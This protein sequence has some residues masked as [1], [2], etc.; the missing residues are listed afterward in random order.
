[1]FHNLKMKIMEA[2]HLKMQIQKVQFFI[3]VFLGFLI[4]LII[5]V[6]SVPD[7]IPLEMMGV[8]DSDLSQLLANEMMMWA[9]SNLWEKGQ[10]GGYVI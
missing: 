4:F 9:L 7:V 3:L 5:D 10:E 1:M 8:I 2:S 6:A